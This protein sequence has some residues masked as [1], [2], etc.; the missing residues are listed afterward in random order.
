MQQSS[1]VYLVDPQSLR[2]AGVEL[3]QRN[4]ENAY[5]SHRELK[6]KPAAERAARYDALKE[7]IRA[8]GFNPLMPITI[9]LLRK[10]GRDRIKDGHH[11][12]AIALELPDIKLIP[13]R[14]LFDCDA[15]EHPQSKCSV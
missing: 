1:A 9:Q 15:L 10:H 12:L 6:D 4:R 2:A 14:F 8:E 5:K 3:I 7:K 11:R 13:V